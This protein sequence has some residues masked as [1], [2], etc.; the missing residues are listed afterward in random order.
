MRPTRL[1]PV[2]DPDSAIRAGWFVEVD[3]R[4]VA[5]LIEPTCVMSSESWYS[6]V[7][8]PVT[9]DPQEREQLFS[10]KFW[11]SGKPVFRSRKF[12]VVAS[13]ALPSLTAPDPDTRRVSVRGLTIR[14][15]PRPGVTDRVA[16]FFQRMTR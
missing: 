1:A 9:K 5:E 6:Y 13:H 11:T 2:D 8:V 7:I 15:N 4:R 10:G 16:Q 12:G 14:L 3:G